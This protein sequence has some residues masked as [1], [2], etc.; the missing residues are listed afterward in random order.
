MSNAVTEFVPPHQTIERL[1]NHPNAKNILEFLYDVLEIESKGKD[2]Y[3]SIMYWCAEMSPDNIVAATLANDDARAELMATL[4]QD[5]KMLTELLDD[6]H[7]ALVKAIKKHDTT[8]ECLAEN[9][10]FCKK[11][12]DRNEGTLCGA[13]LSNEDMMESLAYDDDFVKI[14]SKQNITHLFDSNDLIAELVSRFNKHDLDVKHWVNDIQLNNPK[15]LLTR[16]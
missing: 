1:S 4:S 3:K 16:R 12:V 6:D 14:V 5:T 2:F 9:L 10:E 7:Y 15:A 11:L 8:L 13:I